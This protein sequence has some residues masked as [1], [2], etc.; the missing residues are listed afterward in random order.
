MLPQQSV[1]YTPNTAE[2]G[3]GSNER[4]LTSTESVAA[5]VSEDRLSEKEKEDVEASPAIL[6]GAVDDYP[7]GGFAAWCVVLG[8]SK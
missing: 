3:S 5:K 8:V 7:E 4:G 6:V 2:T 1:M